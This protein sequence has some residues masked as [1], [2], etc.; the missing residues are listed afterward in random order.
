VFDR[1]RE[2]L[3]CV[4]EDHTGTTVINTL[5]A[6]EQ[7]DEYVLAQGN[8]FY[9]SPRLSPDGTRIAWLCWNHPNMPWDG[10][11]LW[12]AEFDESGNFARPS[13][14]A[15]GK[16]ES[17]FQPEW[18][19]DGFLHFVSDR[20]RWWNLCRWR[21]EKIE[22]LCPMEAEFGGAQWVFGLSTY[23][24]VS[25]DKL[26]VSYV[27]EGISHLALLQSGRLAPLNVRYTDISFVRAT[28]DAA[29]FIGA[30]PE[31]MPSIVR[32]GFDG[33]AHEVLQRSTNAR[34]EFVS[35]PRAIEFRA[36]NKKTAHAFFY[37][38]LNPTYQAPEGERPPLIV[39]SHGGP[40]SC[41]TSALSLRIQFWTSR[42]FAVLDVNYGGSTGYGREYRRRLNGQWGI[43]DVNDCVNGALHL[44]TAG[45]VDGNRLI[46]RGQSAGG[47]TTL[48]ALTF[49]DVFK[50]GA[51]YYGVSDLEALDQETHK[52]ESHYNATLIGPYPQARD[53][54]VG[55]SPI[56]FADH[57]R[58]PIIFLQG[59]EDKIVPPDQ[60]EKMF[61]AVREKNLPCAYIAFGGE[62]HG[63]RRAENIKRA[64]EAEL[65]FYSKVFGFELAEAVEP[66]TIE[67]V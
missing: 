2:R 32:L 65:Y 40:T 6:V 33:S 5:V 42:G 67:N 11:E 66:V 23:A 12:A 7:G 52:F 37:P 44:V 10:C 25:A 29:F 8:D 57:L 58:C 20:S 9:S 34:L 18:S 64:L 43:V 21:E 61:N 46:I 30:S 62:Q 24:F 3:I 27:R 1:R 22:A 50:A 59:L 39:I 41:T 51:S 47:Y 14:V 31:E 17:I 19:P 45:E 35:S 15:G 16:N 36:E 4:R 28:Q 60:T 38:P 49:R 63:F 48:C 55:R 54:Y 53:Q 13:K 26:L 56:H